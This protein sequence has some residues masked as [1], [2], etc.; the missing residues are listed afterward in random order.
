VAR[1]DARVLTPLLVREEPTIPPLE[2]RRRPN[3]RVIKAPYYYIVPFGLPGEEG[4]ELAR[5]CVLVNAYTGAFEEVT[6]FGQ[7]LKHLTAQEA[8]G[9]VAAAMR[10]APKRLKVANATLV[11]QA[12]DITHV[13]TYPFWRIETGNRIFYV[14]QVGKLYGKLLPAIPGD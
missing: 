2:R 13:R 9:V 7:P 1:R 8:L 3:A 14:D 11:F 10:I 12:G 4:A 5:V 6:A